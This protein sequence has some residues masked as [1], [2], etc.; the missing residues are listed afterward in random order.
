MI[1]IHTIP[2]FDDNYIWGIQAHDQSG[3]VV[4]DPGDAQAVIRYLNTNKLILKSILIT[5]HHH[6]H[7]G[8][9]QALQTHFGQ[10][11]TVFGPKRETISGITHEIETQESISLLPLELS[12]RVIQV[13][14]HTAG[15][16]AYL[17]ED[18]L[19]CGDTLFS[20]GCGRL[21]EGTAKQ[22][23]SSLKKLA[24]LPPQTRIFCAHEYTQANLAF[25]RDVDPQ[26][27]ML[28][29]Y[30][31][32]VSNL[33]EQRQPSIPSTLE[34][35]LAINPFL[36]CYTSNIRNRIQQQTGIQPQSELETFTLLRKWKDNY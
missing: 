10:Q 11:L 2:A 25:A 9:I 8:G 5:H 26:N 35:E 31:R 29:D 21:F 4:V 16:I 18:N 33:R 14:G 15:H 3:V 28:A 30:V 22:M 17:I 13:P 6:D 27:Q 34:T 23:L 24:E 12:A 32:K 7:T 19:F 1:K 20:G 36:R